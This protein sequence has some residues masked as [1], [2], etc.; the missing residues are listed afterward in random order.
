V[1][2]SLSGGS[3]AT[4]RGGRSG[5]AGRCATSALASGGAG[6]ARERGTFTVTS[7]RPSPTTSSRPPRCGAA[8]G[9]GH[10]RGC[11]RR[12]GLCQRV[13]SRATRSCGT[14]WLSEADRTAVESRRAAA[15]GEN[16]P[17]PGAT[18]SVRKGRSV[19]WVANGGADQMLSRTPHSLR[20]PDPG[21]HR[22][23]QAEEALRESEEPTG[24]SCATFQGIAFRGGSTFT[25]LFFHGRRRV[26]T[27]YRKRSSWRHPRWNEVVH[28]TIGRP[29]ATRSRRSPRV[30]LLDGPRYR[31][32]RKDGGRTLGPGSDLQPSRRLG[33]RCFVEGRNL[34]GHHG[35][36]A[37]REALRDSEEMYRNVAETS[38]GTLIFL[39]DVEG[40][41][42][43]VNSCAARQFSRRRRRWWP[44]AGRALRPRRLAAPGGHPTVIATGEPHH[45]EILEQFPGARSGSTAHLSPY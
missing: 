28:P 22:G 43:Y 34:Y 3:L 11:H 1:R 2:D 8:G 35:A 32:L 42:A 7:P 15:G 40:R 26:L 5:S 19:R 41:V 27:G 45:G 13:S 30:R 14:G 24:R 25:P 9:R 33:E 17:R 37:G 6:P 23:K 21:H 16:P 18:V 29:C 12:H 44:T 10:G 4:T 31:I 39:V 36:Q 20:R 38:I